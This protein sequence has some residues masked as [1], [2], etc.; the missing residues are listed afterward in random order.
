MIKLSKSSLLFGKALSN[1]V[2][3]RDQFVISRE[4][5]LLRGKTFS[6]GL[7][8]F[9]TTLKIYLSVEVPKNNLFC[10]V[11]ILSPFLTYLNPSYVYLDV[12]GL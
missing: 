7:L 4:K 9:C 11:L 12:D 6:F 10:M 5:I 2:S 1:F 8:N 3:L